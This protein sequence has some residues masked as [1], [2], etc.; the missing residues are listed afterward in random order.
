MQIVHIFCN[1]SNLHTRIKSKRKHILFLT[2]F[3]IEKISGNRLALVG[4]AV[5]NKVK[6]LFSDNNSDVFK[7]NWLIFGILIDIYVR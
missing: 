2:G 4:L 5:H 3:I 6:V 7:W 1:S